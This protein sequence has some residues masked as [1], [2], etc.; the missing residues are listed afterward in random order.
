MNF[1]E[2]LNTMS[3]NYNSEKIENVKRILKKSASNGKKEATIDSR[4][5]D[6]WVVKWLIAQ[7][8]TV[9]ETCDQREGDFIRVSW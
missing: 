2:E 5:Y 1:K 4:D 8:L 9:K 3:E 6:K 7:G